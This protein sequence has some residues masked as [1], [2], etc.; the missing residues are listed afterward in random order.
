MIDQG[1]EII[2]SFISKES[3]EK[4]KN[5]IEKYPIPSGAGGIRNANKKIPAIDQ[6][7]HSP[8]LQKKIA[9][10]FSRTPQLVRAIVFNKTHENNWLVSWH[11]DKTVC[12][13]QQFNKLGWGPWTTKDNT[14]HVQVPIYVLEKMFTFRIHL[15]T[16]SNENGCL[17]IF[18]HSDQNGIMT[19]ETIASY[20]KSNIFLECTGDEGSALVMRPHLLHSSLKSNRPA[21]RRILHLEFSDYILP[22]GITWA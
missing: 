13:S 4:I 17:R 19:Q 18:P 14:L 10:Y 20:T 3:N 22:P 6:Y 16:V 1:F 11:Q 7:I 5:E 15:D 12:V 21:Q 8:I 2:E 9:P